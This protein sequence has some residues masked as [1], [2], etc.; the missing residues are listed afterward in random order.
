[1]YADFFGCRYTQAHL[2]SADA[3]TVTLT[4]SP[5]IKVSPKRLD[6]TSIAVSPA[7]GLYDIKKNSIGLFLF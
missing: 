1:M 6:S 7:D 3:N 4:S 2:V 5:M